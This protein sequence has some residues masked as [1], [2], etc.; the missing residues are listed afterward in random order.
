MAKLNQTSITGS[1]TVSGS[2]IL[3]PNL[4]A[5]VFSGSTGQMWVDDSTGIEMKFTRNVSYAAG[6][7]AAGANLINPNHANFAAGFGVQNAGAFA[8]GNGSPNTQTDKTEEYDGTTWSA[9]GTLS[10]SRYKSFLSN[11]A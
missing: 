5:S 4:T 3:M 7:W 11:S 8:G 6:A 2:T 1:L 10:N 9:G